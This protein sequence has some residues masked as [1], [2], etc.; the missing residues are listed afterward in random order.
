M[1]SKFNALEDAEISTDTFSFYVSVSSVLSSKIEGEN[2]ELDS[3]VKHKK[4]GVAFLLDYTKKIDN[5]YNA[6]TFAKN[7]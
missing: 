7:N 6:Y 3:Y 1:Q 5:L 2:I 4:F